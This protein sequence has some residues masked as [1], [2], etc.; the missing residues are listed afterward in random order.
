MTAR[1]YQPAK[2]AMQ[3]GSARTHSWVLEFEPSSK[4]TLDPL[5]GWTGSSDMQR[6]IKLKFD[7][8][9][10]AESYAL[11][12]GLAFEVMLPKKRKRTIQSY[13]ENFS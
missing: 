4:K 5:M 1:I 3:S 13:A 11:R 6:Q 7:T 2:T 10:E 9:N 12:E 8:L